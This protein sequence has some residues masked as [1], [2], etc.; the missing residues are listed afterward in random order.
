MTE[1]LRLL[2]TVDELTGL[3]NRRHFMARLA[4]ET[5]RARRN[6]SQLCLAILDLDHF[7]AINDRYGH[8]AGD[9]VLRQL[10]AIIRDKIRIEDSPAR[11][12]G[13]EF[14]LIL[15]HTNMHQAGLVCDRLRSAVASRL[16]EL[17]GRAAVRVTLSTGVASLNASD[18]GESLMCRSDEALYEA[19]ALGRN[20]VRLAA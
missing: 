20:Q 2:A 19:K 13:E 7:K 18:D 8:A 3:P 11:I 6:G 16:F 1:E 5:A 4:A 10:A 14:A 9:A 15:P 17:P 12:G